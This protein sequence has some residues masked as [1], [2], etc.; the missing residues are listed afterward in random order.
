MLQMNA[1][2]DGQDLTDQTGSARP[3]DAQQRANA[4]KDAAINARHIA[5][6]I[7]DKAG[8]NR[9]ASGLR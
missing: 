1:R 4:R 7:F 8:R 6:Q 5:V 9:P 2:R 3:Q